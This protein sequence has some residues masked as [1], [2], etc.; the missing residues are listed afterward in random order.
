MFSTADHDRSGRVNA[1]K[2][3]RATSGKYV[4]SNN[5]SSF[6]RVSAAIR[7]NWLRVLQYYHGDRPILERVG[8][9]IT[10]PEIAAKF[11]TANSYPLCI[12]SLYCVSLNLLLSSVSRQ[13]LLNVMTDLL[14]RLEFFIKHWY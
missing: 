6:V 8:A 5:Q 2:I 10:S 12:T 1:S 7:S 14:Q 11:E 13:R 4:F 3:V 9:P